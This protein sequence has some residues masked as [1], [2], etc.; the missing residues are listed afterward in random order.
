MIFMNIGNLQVEFP[1]E[2]RPYVH[3][4][5]GATVEEKI[6]IALA[7][8]LFLQSKINIETAAALSGQSPAHF[9][10]LSRSMLAP[11]MQESS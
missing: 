8:E 7:M 5:A 3:R 6:R 2:F 11:W 4:L 10:E 9:V 1:E